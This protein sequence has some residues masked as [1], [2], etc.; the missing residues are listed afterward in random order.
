MNW[1]KHPAADTRH[2][3]F[4]KLM[5]VTGYPRYLLI[6]AWEAARE[7]ASAR[8]DRG[9]VKGL[10][11]ETLALTIG[12]EEG[13]AKAILNA[14]IKKELIVK[15][16]DVWCI[17]DWEEEQGA[18]PSAAE[19]MRAYR[20]RKAAVTERN[21]PNG[22]DDPAKGCT[23]KPRKP[24]KKR[25]PDKGLQESATQRNALRQL[26]REEEIREDK[27]DTP[28]TPTGL[29]PPKGDIARRGCRLPSDFVPN[30]AYALSEG[31]TDEQ[32]ER[33]AKKFANHWAAQTGT[34]GRKADWNATWR[35]WVLKAV[36][37]T[38]R[39]KSLPV[40][41]Y[42]GATDLVAYEAELRARLAAE[43]SAN[44]H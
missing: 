43:E 4:D 8:R 39:R 34:R 37:D 35:N 3:R 6:A 32:A 31:L 13:E 33:E 9:S 23:G 24:R 30:L 27:K 41:G 28:P 16:D 38:G 22:G 25:L 44:V 21:G 29:I 7:Y 10:D 14:C 2:V 15:V 18:D 20:A 5:S 40:N 17:A 36:E 42:G 19:R 1:H 26:L 12:C 11:P